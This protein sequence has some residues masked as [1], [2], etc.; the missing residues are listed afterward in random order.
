MRADRPRQGQQLLRDFGGQTVLRYVL[1]DRGALA[2]PFEIGSE[3]P[4]LEFDAVAELGRLVRRASAALP[5]R[6]GVFAFGVI[7]AGDERAELAAAQAQP[8][9]ATLRA[10]PRVA[11]VALVGEQPRREEF[12]ERGG[13]LATVSARSLRP[14]WA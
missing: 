3:P 8:A 13:D 5:E 7:G 11:T 4:D 12:V 1:G 10:Q 2:V 14:P 6:P 9:F